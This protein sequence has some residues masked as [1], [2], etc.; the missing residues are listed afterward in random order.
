MTDQVVELLGCDPEDV[1]H[2]SGKEGLGIE[3][4]LAAIIEKIPAPKGDPKKPLQAMIFDSQFNSYRGIEVIFRVF[5]GTIRKGDK[6]KF[7]NT[8]KTYNADELVFYGLSKIRN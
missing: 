6:I 4:I 3:E 7:V 2:A 5:N 8:D 1:I